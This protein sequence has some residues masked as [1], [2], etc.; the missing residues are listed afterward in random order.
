MHSCRKG[1]FQSHPYGPARPPDF[2]AAEASCPETADA[3]V[4]LGSNRQATSWS[5]E[6]PRR[7]GGYYR[8]R[9]RY[10]KT[11]QS[12]LS[13]VDRGPGGMGAGREQGPVVRRTEAGR[14]IRSRYARIWGT[15]RSS[16]ASGRVSYMHSGLNTFTP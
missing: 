4:T 10:K 16:A 3:S 8:P 7:N 11:F 1:D 5:G 13:P 2:G 9:R 12:P 14:G 6:D 15:F